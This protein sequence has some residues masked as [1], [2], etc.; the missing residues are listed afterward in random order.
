MQPEREE[1]LAVA[2][3]LGPV[4]LWLM[5]KENLQLYW[6]LKNGWC[7]LRTKIWWIARQL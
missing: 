1:D 2:L 7:K 4:E 6:L 5:K 3:E